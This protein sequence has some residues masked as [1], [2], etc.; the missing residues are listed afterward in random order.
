[1]AP[2]P[3]EKVDQIDNLPMGILLLREER[4]FGRLL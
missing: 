2:I 4:C 3:L 1:M